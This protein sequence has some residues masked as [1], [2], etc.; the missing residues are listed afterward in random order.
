MSVIDFEMPLLPFYF[1]A[2][3]ISIQLV[4][5]A[6][7]CV[8]KGQPYENNVGSTTGYIIFIRL[9]SYGRNSLYVWSLYVEAYIQYIRLVYGGFTV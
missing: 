2:K 7:A 1:R 6:Y 3:L 5:Y 4:P 8:T 9:V